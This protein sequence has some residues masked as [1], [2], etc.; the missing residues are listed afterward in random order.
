M[1]LFS[2]E[3]NSA[4]FYI[5]S[6]VL[7]SNLYNDEFYKGFIKHFLKSIMFSKDLLKFH[8]VKISFVACVHS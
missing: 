1:S 8:Y 6:T 2:F 7:P 4:S 5:P 3:V